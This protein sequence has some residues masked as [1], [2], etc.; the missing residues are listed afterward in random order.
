MR[1][2][3]I[4]FLRRNHATN[5]QNTIQITPGTKPKKKSKTV[6]KNTKNNS[7]PIV[8]RVFCAFC[9]I[10]FQPLANLGQPKFVFSQGN[11]SW[12]DGTSGKT[13][14]G[15][16]R[17]FRS[18]L[19]LATRKTRSTRQ[20]EIDRLWDLMNLRWI[21]TVQANSTGNSTNSNSSNQTSNS[22][23]NSTSNGTSTRSR[24]E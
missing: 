7:A 4:S 16:V 1:W 6:K 9:W 19:P 11:T 3:I 10:A 8:L 5:L 24:T 21:H 23:S 14:V 13:Q 17:H 12:K 2:K 22:T 20:R 15:D 18:P